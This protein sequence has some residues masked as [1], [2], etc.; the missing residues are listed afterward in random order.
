MDRQQLMRQPASSS[1]VLFTATRQMVCGYR[2]PRGPARQ[3]RNAASQRGCATI[4]GC[5]RATHSRHSG[6][7]D[8]LSAMKLPVR[9]GLASQ[10]QR[11]LSEVRIFLI[12]CQPKVQ[13]RAP[14]A[15]TVEFTL[16]ILLGQ[17]C[18]LR[19]ALGRGQHGIQA[20]RVV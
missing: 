15:G 2:T 11:G 3:L 14:E 7:L 1:G 10:Q 13:W 12:C 9:P 18:S 16:Q 20:V 8:A 5:T 4:R 19:V 17:L 6:A